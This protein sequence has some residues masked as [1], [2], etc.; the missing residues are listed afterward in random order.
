M[1]THRLILTKPNR[2]RSRDGVKTMTRRVCRDQTAKSYQWVE[3]IPVY[4]AGGKPYTGWAKDCGHSFLIPTKARYQVGDHLA[5]LEPYQI[6][7]MNRREATG[8]YTDDGSEFRIKLTLPEWQQ[9]MDR[10]R[11][12]ARTSARY[13]YNSLIRTRF[14][15]TGVGCEQLQSIGEADALAEGGWEYKSCPIHKSPIRSFAD[16]WDSIYAQPKPVGNKE[17]GITHYVSYPWDDS[18]EYAKMKTYRDK[19][20]QCYPNPWVWPYSYKLIDKE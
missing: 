4:P 19:P 13:M 14:V 10:K 3:N 5:M 7:G 12:D 16:L 1:K 17:D 11:P 9:W 20:H 8:N 6:C 18:G 2:Q 15:V